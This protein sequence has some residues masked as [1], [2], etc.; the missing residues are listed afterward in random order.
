MLAIASRFA[1]PL[2]YTPESRARL[3]TYATLTQSACVPVARVDA[4]R[5]RNV[6]DPVGHRVLFQR[7]CCRRRTDPVPGPR[8]SHEEWEGALRPCGEHPVAPAT[9]D[10]RADRERSRL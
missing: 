3:R 1:H 10:A 2:K 7:N 6:S 8:P 4:G 5:P 9:V